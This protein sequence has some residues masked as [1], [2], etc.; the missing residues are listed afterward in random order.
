MTGSIVDGLIPGFRQHL[1]GGMAV[2]YCTG[3][4]NGKV[5]GPAQG[6]SADSAISGTC[7]AYDNAGDQLYQNTT[8]S[9][10]QKLGST[11]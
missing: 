1:G 11:A 2:L 7:I 3:D 10:W 6:A 9:T 4:P 5:T 8:G